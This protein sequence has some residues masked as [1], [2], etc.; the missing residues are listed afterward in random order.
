MAERLA[1]VF[2]QISERVSGY[3]CNMSCTSGVQ[4]GDAMGM[5]LFHMPI[6]VVLKS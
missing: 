1:P 5:A 2:F 3:W 4:Q 6:L